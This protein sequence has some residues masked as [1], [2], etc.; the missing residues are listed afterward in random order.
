MIENL[1]HNQTILEAVNTSP[2][3]EKPKGARIRKD[4]SIQFIGSQEVADEPAEPKESDNLNSWQNLGVNGESLP[5]IRHPKLNRDLSAVKPSQPSFSNL[6]SSPS[7]PP[8]LIVKGI[9]DSK[10]LS[11][12]SP[13]SQ[14]LAHLQ[15]TGFRLQN[16]SKPAIPST[17]RASQIKNQKL[18]KPVLHEKVVTSPRVF[19]DSVQQL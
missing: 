19:D 3:D 18:L 15:D 11:L 4:P 13:S 1:L 10:Q 14:D 17:S 6:R 9:S 12:P 7:R 2:E 5:Q 8:E 16:L